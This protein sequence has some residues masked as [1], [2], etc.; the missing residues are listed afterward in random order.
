M[1][2][3]T[4]ADIRT[5]IRN[6]TGRPN[7][8][9]ISNEDINARMNR[10]YQ[11]VL[12]KEL[13]IFWGYTYY[14][15]FTQPN[16]DQYVS[17]F[18][19]FQTFN[20]AVT[21]DGFPI[22]WYIDPDIF[23]QNYPLQ[24]N[25]TVVG[26]G[27]GSTATFGFT[28]PA[29][30]VLRNSVYVT[31]GT[32][33]VSDDGSGVFTGNGSGTINYSSGVCSVT[34]TANSAANAN[35]VQSSYTY[36]AAKPM[37]ILYYRGAYLSNSL[38]DTRNN[39]N[40]FVLRPVPDQVYAVRLRGIQVPA[41]LANDTDVPFRSDLGPLIAYGTSLDI[42]SDYNQMDQYRETM[43]EYERYKSVCLQDTIE[44]YLYQRSIPKF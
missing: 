10:Y 12:P 17:P 34:F 15:F 21:V 11:F 27:D 28:I 43:V 37:G 7:A 24:L 36:M 5:K 20:P 32:Q 13:K 25:K 40:Y 30:P 14:N 42:F 31:D 18:N 22:N 16:V 39:Q 19:T 33:V 8:S 2:E 29:V 1:A 38:P 41:A 44:E 6:V 23:Y 9:M 4:R 26:Q 35:I 3:W